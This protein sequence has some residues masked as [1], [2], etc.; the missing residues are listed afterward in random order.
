MG[1]LVKMFN[2]ITRLNIDAYA[3]KLPE[4]VRE[5]CREA[6]DYI[7]QGREILTRLLLYFN[8]SLERP[9]AAAV[10]CKA[11]Y[12]LYGEY[13]PAWEKLPEYLRRET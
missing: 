13:P 12:H 4:I 5:D 10:Y 7:D 2:L 11:F 8:P 1:G 6:A 3:G 9:E